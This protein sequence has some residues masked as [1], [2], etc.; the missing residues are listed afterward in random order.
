MMKV[1]K[2]QK[3][4]DN[5]VKYLLS[6]EDGHSVEALFMNDKSLE[7]TYHSTVCVSS[8]V[9]CSIGCRFCATGKQGFIRNLSDDEIVSQ[10][11]FCDRFRH[12]AGYIPLDAVVFAGMGEPLLNYDNVTAAIGK[13]KRNLGLSHFELATAGIVP[14]IYDLIGFIKSNDIQLR[15]NVSLHA[16]TDEKRSQLIPYTK[17][18]GVSDIISAATDFAEATGTKARIRYMLLS[19]LNDTD[20]DIHQL[21]QLL[22]GKPVKLIISEYN[23]NTI[24]GLTPSGPLDVLNFYSKIKENIDCDIFHNFGGAILGGCGQLRQ[25]NQAVS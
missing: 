3:S 5:A 11:D 7:L 8:Q 20:K 12:L 9:G 24:K 18:Y 10:V 21:T 2:E 22:Q 1:I 13:I 25:H 23:D 16:A 4:E 6:L 19:G 15:L 14:R 17:K